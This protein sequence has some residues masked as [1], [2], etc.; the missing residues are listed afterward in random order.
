MSRLRIT[1]EDGQERFNFGGRFELAAADYNADGSADFTLGTWGSSSMGIYYLYTV[2]ANGQITMAYPHGIA[3]VGL[4]F[5]RVFEQT[6]DGN[7]FAVREY[8]NA[9]AEYSQI[10]YDWDGTQYMRREEP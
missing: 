6:A 3:D 10:D 7:G 2:D 9:S 8:S 5:S 1:D 4:D